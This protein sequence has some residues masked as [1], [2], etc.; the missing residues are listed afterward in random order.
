MKKIILVIGL[1]ATQ[2]INAYM[3]T[4]L[5][6]IPLKGEVS[7]IYGAERCAALFSYFYAML[8]KSNSNNAKKTSEKYLTRYTY[9]K[10]I[11]WGMR[12][13]FY[14]V[15]DEKAQKDSSVQFRKFVDIYLK[16]GKE[17]FSRNGGYF[18]GI[19]KADAQWCEGVYRDLKEK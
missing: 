14:K 9:M 1:I 16:D 3:F 10:T 11:S 12:V 17:A 8:S 4:P 6:Q 15:S 13:A 7:L 19:I 5:D 18:T 2:N